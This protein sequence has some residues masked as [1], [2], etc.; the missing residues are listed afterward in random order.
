MISNFIQIVDDNNN[1]PIN[2]DDV[3][4]WLVVNQHKIRKTLTNRYEN[5][6]DYIKTKEKMPSGQYQTC[7]FAQ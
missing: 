3:V 6:I 4:E 5:E 7:P 1:F 2:L